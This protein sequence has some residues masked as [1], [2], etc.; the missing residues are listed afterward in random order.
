MCDD[1][2]IMLLVIGKFHKVTDFLVIT[3]ARSSFREVISYS[4]V[5]FHNELGWDVITIAKNQPYGVIPVYLCFHP[6]FM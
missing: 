6:H 2:V 4:Q 5:I 3:E 1:Y